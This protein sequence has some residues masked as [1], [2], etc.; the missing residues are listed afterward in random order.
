MSGCE[1]TVSEIS[2][3]MCCCF[4]FTSPV[5]ATCRVLVLATR[6]AETSCRLR[7]LFRVVCLL[8]RGHKYCANP[9]PRR[10]VAATLEARVT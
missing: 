6:C 3:V 7:W 1:F 10:T 9:E 8:S 2:L 4:R 5:K